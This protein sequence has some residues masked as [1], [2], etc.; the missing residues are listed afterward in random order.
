ML[1]LA[2]SPFIGLAVL[3]RIGVSLSLV[4]GHALS[5]WL[6]IIVVLVYVGGVIIIF[7]YLTRLLSGAKITTFSA[8]L[9]GLVGA[10]LGS[11]FVTNFTYLVPQVQPLWLCQGLDSSVGALVCYS[12]MYLLLALVIVFFITSKLDGPIKQ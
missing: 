5:S 2:P 9:T 10:G 4:M 3:L 11:G 7:V 12:I 1:T 8:R 6:F